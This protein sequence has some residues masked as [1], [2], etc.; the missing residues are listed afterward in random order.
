MPAPRVREATREGSDADEE[1]PL[2]G[3]HDSD[4]DESYEDF[5]SVRTVRQHKNITRR[6]LISGAVLL[7][8][9]FT[10]RAMSHGIL[11]PIA[12]FLGPLDLMSAVENKTCGLL[13]CLPDAVCCGQSAEDQMCCGPEAICC[14]NTIC[15]APNGQC[16]GSICCTGDDVCCGGEICCAKG[17]ICTTG[18]GGTRICSAAGL[19]PTQTQ[20]EVDGGF[21]PFQA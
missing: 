13:S 5:E 18:V 19:V 9:A 20:A 7:A 1:E 21:N 6:I 4:G 12:S 3:H 2:T 11:G 16:C 10:G 8:V 15:C 14:Q 17:D